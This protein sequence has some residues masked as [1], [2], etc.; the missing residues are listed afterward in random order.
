MSTGWTSEDLE[1]VEDAIRCMIKGERPVAETISGP[2]GDRI[3]QWAN[4]TLDQLRALR[5][6]IKASLQ[7][8]NHRPRIVRTRFDKGL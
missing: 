1:L 2:A 4:V 7:T 3:K 6:E 5:D 8:A